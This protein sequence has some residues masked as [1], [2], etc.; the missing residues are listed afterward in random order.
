[1]NG[2]FNK[3]KWLSLFSF[4]IF[5]ISQAVV[6]ISSFVFETILSL[7]SSNLLISRL[8]KMLLPLMI[9]ILIKYLLN[10]YKE[11][12]ETTLIHNL[13]A[14]IYKIYLKN[15]YKNPDLSN[16]EFLELINKDITVTMQR[17]TQSYPQIL[18]SLIFLAI[19]LTILKINNENIFIFTCLSSLIYVIF[20]LVAN[21]KFQINY[22]DI[23]ELESK[24]TDFYINS[25]SAQS[26][27]LFHGVQYIQKKLNLLI[28]LYNTK[29][30][31]SEFLAQINNAVNDFLKYFLKFGSIFYGLILINNSELTFAQFIGLNVI[32]MNVIS[33]VDNI[34]RYAVT[35]KIQKVALNRINNITKNIDIQNKDHEF[36]QSHDI[37]IKDLSLNYGNN[38][39]LKNVNLVIKD[40]DKVLLKGE[41]G[42]GKS[43]LIK[44]IVKEIVNYEGEVEINQYFSHSLSKSISYIPQKMP[45]IHFT[46]NDFKEIYIQKQDIDIDRFY[47]IYE[48]LNGELSNLSKKLNELSSGEVKKVII[49]LELSKKSS[50]ILMDEPTNYLDVNSIQSLKELLDNED[51]TTILVAHDTYLVNCCN[52]HLE[53]I[54]GTIYEKNTFTNKTKTMEN[55]SSL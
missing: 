31:E 19:S 48:K 22:S 4:L 28:S 7:N 43:S 9:L 10:F 30:S 36:V 18:G 2:I 38:P 29:G 41:N 34:S 46:G 32:M 53:I 35:H 6:F 11:Y 21:K 16:G 47:K 26:I 45:I 50:L 52:R 12:K 13:R 33:L 49:A 54:E 23:V 51:K 44:I 39:V 15:F 24:L 8:I 42:S 27:F 40:K 20:P 25:I 37:V 1:M 3:A 5:I 17:Y 55:N 14:S